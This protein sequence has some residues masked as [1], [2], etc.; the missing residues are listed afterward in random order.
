MRQA[1]ACALPF[2]DDR[3]DRSMSLLVLHFVPEAGKAIPSSGSLSRS[4]A[5][6]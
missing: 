3:F 6:T 1:D 5:I 2:E 4:L